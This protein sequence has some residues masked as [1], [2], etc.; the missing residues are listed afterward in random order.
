MIYDYIFN[1]ITKKTKIMINDINNYVEE[2]YQ[3]N[4]FF[5][6]WDK[7]VREKLT[8]NGF[9]SND[10]ITRHSNIVK[11]YYI[12]GSVFLLVLNFFLLINDPKTGLNHLFFYSICV[13]L[14]YYKNK[15]IKMFS[16]WSVYEYKKVKSLKK[17]LNDFTI[18]EE[19]SPEY[20][21]LLEDYMVYAAIFDMY[22]MSPEEAMKEIRL[23]LSV[24]NS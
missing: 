20:V 24:N 1:T 16:N 18:I 8:F 14:G 19:R 10:F 4:S 9:Y 7:L 17:F 21:K 13:V 23:F 5:E 12:F 22:D 11:K 3:N 6:E 15:N 2:N